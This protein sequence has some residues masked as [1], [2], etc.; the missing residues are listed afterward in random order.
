MIIAVNFGIS[1]EYVHNFCATYVKAKFV[2]VK[3]DAPKDEDDLYR[4]EPV[5]T[6]EKDVYKLYL[7]KNSRDIAW[8]IG[9]TAYKLI[10]VNSDSIKPDE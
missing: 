1:G 8:F 6:D 3:D 5:E 7:E 9:Q 10:K 2:K 4:T